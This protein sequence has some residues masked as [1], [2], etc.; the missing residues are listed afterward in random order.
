VSRAFALGPAST[1]LALKMAG[2]SRVDGGKFKAAASHNFFSQCVCLQIDYV[3]AHQAGCTAV[4]A[5]TFL[6]LLVRLMLLLQP[7]T[8]GGSG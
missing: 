1:A 7:G 3:T 2:L 4:A 8:Q 5:G 6:W